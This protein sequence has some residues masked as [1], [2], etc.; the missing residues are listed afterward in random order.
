MQFISS[1]AWLDAV[2][3]YSCCY[4]RCC[5]IE[6][7]LCYYTNQNNN[8]SLLDLLHTLNTY[9]LRFPIENSPLEIVRDS[10]SVQSTEN[11]AI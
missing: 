4:C 2:S 5:T 11:L 7:I 1:I 9:S 8:V 3:S 6:K 10:T